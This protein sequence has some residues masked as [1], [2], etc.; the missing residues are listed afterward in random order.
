MMVNFAATS[1]PFQDR[2]EFDCRGSIS[3][4]QHDGKKGKLL[5]VPH[6]TITIA[7]IKTNSKALGNAKAHHQT[8]YFDV[9]T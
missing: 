7:E 8:E 6:I 4:I 9:H 5:K 2:L 1:Q 3:V